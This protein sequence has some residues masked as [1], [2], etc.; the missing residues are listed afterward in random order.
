MAEVPAVRESP[1]GLPVRFSPEALDTM[2]QDLEL[3]GDYVQSVLE[4]EVDYGTIPGVPQPFLWEPGADK[5]LAAFNCYP[6]PQVLKEEIDEGKR[7]ITYI[8]CAEVV[9]R[10]SGQVVA[11]GIGVASTREGKYGAR[12]VENPQDYGYD[13]AALRRRRN[14]KTERIEFRMPNPDWA[15]LVHTLL[16]MAY[17]RAKVDAVQGL[18]GA[19]SALRRLFQGRPARGGAAPAGEE[20]AEPWPGEPGE[21]AGGQ[22]NWRG[23]WGEMNRLGILPDKVHEVLGVRSLKDD[24]V[25]GGRTLEEAR[26][27]VFRALGIVAPERQRL[28]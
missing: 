26:Q 6:R 13:P 16:Q 3:L 7:L 9:S 21:N 4:R 19:S 24:W 28:L 12:W 22:P 17:K 11:T 15:D 10:E 25:A 27:K 2:R 14:R 8:V 5:I 18:P 20:P 1:R 23:F